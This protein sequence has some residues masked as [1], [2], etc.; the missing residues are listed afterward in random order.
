MWHPSTKTESVTSDVTMEEILRLQELWDITSTALPENLLSLV[1]S[2]S[3]R[4]LVAQE[5]H[6]G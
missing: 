1:V 5:L 3:P 4:G 2:R 6:S